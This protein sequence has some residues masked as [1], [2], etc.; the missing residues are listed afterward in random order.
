[1]LIFDLRVGE[2][3]ILILRLEVVLLDDRGDCD[4]LIEIIYDAGGLRLCFLF[5]FRIKFFC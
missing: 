5:F 2:L 1:M 3:C 4:N